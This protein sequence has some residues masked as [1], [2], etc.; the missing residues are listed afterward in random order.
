MWQRLIV[1]GIA[2][3]VIYFLLKNWNEI[4]DEIAS[5][6]RTNHY[7]GIIKILCMI[8][9]A[10]AGVRQLTFKFLGKKEET[11]LQEPEIITTQYIKIEDLPPEFQY[12]GT[13]EHK[14]TV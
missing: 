11:Y 3:V 8:E 5:W 4:I 1:T 12:I 10:H 9:N 2:T 7:H 14:I 6:A 13:R